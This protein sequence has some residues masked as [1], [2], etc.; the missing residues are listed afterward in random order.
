MIQHQCHDTVVVAS[1][2]SRVQLFCNPTDCSLPGSSVHG[3]LQA[4]ILEWVASPFSRGSSQPR[5]WTLVSHNAGR[6]FTIWAT[7]EAQIRSIYASTWCSP[8]PLHVP[9]PGRGEGWPAHGVL[10]CHHSEGR[11]LI[12]WQVRIL[13][14]GDQFSLLNTFDMWGTTTELKLI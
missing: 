11:Y 10:S 3:T 2:L 1:L 13:Y 6:F 7:R 8:W 9:P 14:L 5:D 4:R 12:L